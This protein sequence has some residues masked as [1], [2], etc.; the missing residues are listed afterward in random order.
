MYTLG[1]TAVGGVLGSASV[2]LPMLL[3]AVCL[4]GFGVGGNI[5]VDSAMFAEFL[6]VNKRGLVMGCV[7]HGRV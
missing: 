4:I 2:Q 5:P 3:G 7:L 1:L 6:P